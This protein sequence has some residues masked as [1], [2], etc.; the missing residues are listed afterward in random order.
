M[1]GTGS[2]L[3]INAAELWFA[4]AAITGDGIAAGA[5]PL[6]KTAARRILG[7]GSY[8]LALPSTDAFSGR[9]PAASRACSL[10]ASCR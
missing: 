6:H 7:S 4:N 3:V 5:M 10:A 8:A 9:S 2:F 1:H